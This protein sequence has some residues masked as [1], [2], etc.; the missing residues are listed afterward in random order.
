MPT[1]ADW[2]CKYLTTNRIIGQIPSLKGAMCQNGPNVKQ[3]ADPQSSLTAANCNSHLLK[4][5][6][7]AVQLVVL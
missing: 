7:L 3:K 1:F 5:A 6:Q 2:F 4:K